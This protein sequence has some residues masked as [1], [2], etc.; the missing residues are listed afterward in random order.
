[1][2]TWHI[3]A[4]VTAHSS[5]GTVSQYLRTL[6]TGAPGE[7]HQYDIHREADEAMITQHLEPDTV[8]DV[9]VERVGR[10]HQEHARG[11]HVIAAAKRESRSDVDRKPPRIDATLCRTVLMIFVD[12]VHSVEPGR[13]HD[14]C[15]KCY[16]SYK[17]DCGL[18][19]FLL[20]HQRKNIMATPPTSAPREYDPT[21]DTTHMSVMAVRP[22]MT[23]LF[24]I[25][26]AQVPD[27]R[28]DRY[29]RQ[30]HR[31]CFRRYNCR[32]G[33]KHGNDRPKP[34]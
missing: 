21:T 23:H 19:L 20:W 9:V 16:H 24:F 12:R 27:Q 22:S 3:R 15:N 32:Q 29:Q 13:R 17:N 30:G 2:Q 8:R 1:M 18:R 14:D 28:Q 10:V 33:R 31:R 11:E 26:R 34:A 6:R 7:D 5:S 25:L 4:S